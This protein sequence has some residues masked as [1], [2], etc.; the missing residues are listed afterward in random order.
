VNTF[1]LHLTT[2]KVILIKRFGDVD[3]IIN[4]IGDGS[5]IQSEQGKVMVALGHIVYIE[6][7]E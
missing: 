3:S 5:V 4:D 7:V 2:G 6:I 1:R